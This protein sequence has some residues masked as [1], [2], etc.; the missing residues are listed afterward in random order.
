L[1]PFSVLKVANQVSRKKNSSFEMAAI[2]FCEIIFLNIDSL[3][4]NKTK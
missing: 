4:D 1:L 2:T 3:S